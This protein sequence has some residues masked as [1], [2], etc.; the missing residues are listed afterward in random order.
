MKMCTTDNTIPLHEEKRD[1]RKWASLALVSKF[2]H[3]ILK[4]M[5]DLYFRIRT[6]DITKYC[7]EKLWMPN[8]WMLLPWKCSRSG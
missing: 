5:P 8:P 3:L 1:T 4:W 7:S 2:F 6:L